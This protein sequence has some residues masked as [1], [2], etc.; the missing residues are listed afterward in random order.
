[1]HANMRLKTF[2]MYTNIWAHKMYTI[3]TKKSTWYFLNL[4]AVINSKKQIT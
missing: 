1:M 4:L 3:F 2:K